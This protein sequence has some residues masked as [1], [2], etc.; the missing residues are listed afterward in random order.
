MYS[1]QSNNFPLTC[2]C[3]W[4]DDG[5]LSCTS[6]QK[7]GYVDLLEM[8]KEDSMSCYYGSTLPKDSTCFLASSWTETDP[9][10]FLIRSK[11]YLEDRKKV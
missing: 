10:T 2:L 6:V 1:L 7:R 4:F 8:A 5:W 11:S 3:V 9:S